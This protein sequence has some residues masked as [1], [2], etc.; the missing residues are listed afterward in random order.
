MGL[1]ALRKY[2]TAAT[3]D[4]ICLRTAG[5]ADIR[6]NPT[7]AA[8]DVKISLNGGAFANLATLPS[9]VPASG[10]NIE[11]ALSSGETTCARA[12]IHFIDQTSPKEWDDFEVVIETFGNA[13][14]QFAPDYSN[15]TSLG[16]ADLDATISSRMATFTYTAPPT[17]GAI[18]TA[19]W[20]DATAGDFTVASSIGKA[21]YIANVAPGAAGGH[22]IAGANATT[23]VNFTGNLSGSVGSVTG[24]V[25]SVTGNVGGNVVGSVGSLS[26]VTFPTNFGALGINASGHVLRVVLADTVT[27]YTGNTPQT[28]DSFARL[29]V[30]VFGTTV[31]DEIVHVGALVADVQSKATTIIGLNNSI[32]AITDQITSFDFL[33][34]GTRF[35]TMLET[36]GAG[37]Y[38]YTAAALLNAP[39]GGGGGSGG[40]VTIVEQDS[41]I[42]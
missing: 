17:V 40:T 1:S 25:G 21:L 33:T 38:R 28:G 11:V 16:L 7:L 32:K 4:G 41:S 39:S 22:F 23:T 36:P 20:Q 19:I 3:I 24:A 37:I 10:K 34:A 15:A 6:A 27:T 35:L 18:A 5:T 9:A 2:A 30:P 13:S 8:G 26:G 31:I 12:V 14:G 42:S 29:G